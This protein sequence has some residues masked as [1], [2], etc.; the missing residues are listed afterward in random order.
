MLST[1]KQNPELDKY[2]QD[3]EDNLDKSKPL[4]SKEKVRELAK[5]KSAA[6][7]RPY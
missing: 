4:S 6:S 7:T 3:I 5:L 2:E 1:K